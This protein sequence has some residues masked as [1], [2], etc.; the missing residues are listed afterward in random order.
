MAARVD[1]NVEDILS[2]Y[3]LNEEDLDRECPRDVML[4]VAVKLDDW[5]MVGYF[6]YLYS[7]EALRKTEI[8]N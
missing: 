2:R 6:L 8:E 4:E 1:P 3:R 5:Q 7:K